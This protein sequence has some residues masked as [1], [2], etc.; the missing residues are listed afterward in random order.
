MEA[1]T[2]PTPTPAPAPTPAPSPTA[3]VTVPV[4]LDHLQALQESAARLRQIEADN[5]RL[6]REAEAARLAEI[7]AKD[8]TAKALEEAKIA[9]DKEAADLAAERDRVRNA[10]HTAER[11]REIASLLAGL[12][13]AWEGALDHVR[14]LISSR[15]STREVDGKPLVVETATG[16]P[17]RDVIP[18][19][20]ATKEFSG[21]VK[22]TTTGGS[23]ATQARQAAAP[24][25]AEP[26]NLGQL[27][28]K[29]HRERAAQN[30]PVW[31][32]N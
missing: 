10:W 21:F 7:A 6:A 9:R 17:A 30:R 20:L 32:Q 19:I 1:E 14:T 24:A 29:E 11:D 16:R 28:L 23:G 27:W 31:R 12:S 26:Q 4:A 22:P 18:E 15:F 8:G 5:T 3:A 25:E 13:P 2:N